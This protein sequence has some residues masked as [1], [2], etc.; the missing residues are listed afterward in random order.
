G[1]ERKVWSVVNVPT[2]ADEDRRQLHRGLKDLQRQQ[3]EG[4]NRSKGLLTSPGRPAPVDANCRTTLAAVRDLGGQAVPVGLQERLLQE[5]AVWEALYRQ[6]RDA[7][8]EPER[9]RRGKNTLEE[10]T[11]ASENRHE[12][13]GADRPRRQEKCL[14]GLDC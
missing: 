5:F 7:A 11:D 2:V 4:S 3:T 10:S 6:V 8:N 9:R 13:G 12:A 1:G 14:M